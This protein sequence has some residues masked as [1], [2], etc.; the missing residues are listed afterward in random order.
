MPEKDLYR[1]VQL[2]SADEM[3]WLRVLREVKERKHSWWIRFQMTD[4]IFC[5]DPFTLQPTSYRLLNK[6]VNIHHFNS[7]AA[8]KSRN[9]RYSPCAIPYRNSGPNKH[10]CIIQRFV[11]YISMTFP[12]LSGFIHFSKTF[13]GLENAVLKFHDF[14]R[15]FMTVRTLITAALEKREPKHTLACVASLVFSHGD[16]AAANPPEGLSQ[17]LLDGLDAWERPLHG[18]L[19]T[20]FRVHLQMDSKQLLAC[21]K[22][23]AKTQLIELCL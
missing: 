22:S 11:N 15:F 9:M 4:L 2:F 5:V 16:P 18:H 17:R 23:A 20:G 21:S 7:K 13:P 3:R 8:R 1:T 12:K 6:C 19:V 10:N 14:S